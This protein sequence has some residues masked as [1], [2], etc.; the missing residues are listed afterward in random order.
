MLAMP[1]PGPLQAFATQRRTLLAAGMA[2]LLPAV[3]Q[4]QAPAPQPALPAEVLAELQRARIPVSALAC[5]A[6][7]LGSRRV[8]LE[9]QS[10]QMMNPA[11]VVK[12]VTTA[13]ALDQLGPAW[14]WAT[15]VWIRGTPDARGVLEGNVH[16]QGSGDPK[17]VF[18]RVW[19][20]L[21]RVQQMGVRDLRG[22]FVLD[23]SAFAAPEATPGDFDGEHLR[24]YNAQPAA[25]LLNYSARVYGFVPDPAREVA[26]V[27]IEPPLVG[28]PL[29]RSVPLNSGPCDD[30]RAGLQASFNAGRP[31]FA[32]SYP[33][34]CGERQ[35]VLADP[36][37]ASYNRRLIEGLWR[38]MG[39]RLGGRVRSGP[40]PAGPPSFEIRSPPLLDVVRDIN[41]FSNNVMAQQ[42][43][44]TLAL[45]RDPARPATAEAARENLR[46]WLA[47]RLGPLPAETVIDN[48]SGLSRLTRMSAAT[49]VAL[50]QLAWESPWMSELISS[51]PV[52]GT[53][54]T[55][56]RSRAGNGRAH[57]KT[58]TLRDSAALA[59]VVLGD[60]GRRYAFV[61]MVNHP[62]AA[63]ARQALDALVAWT[64]RD[65]TGR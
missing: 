36:E 3:L 53:D 10:R 58:G 54:G 20:L 30:W 27:T 41:K 64:M 45:Q 40:A 51:L 17:L 52:S 19:L 21:R 6:Q 18:E 44:L 61:A 33:A 11:S 25:L 32:G 13:A 7:E 49:L 35:W 43:A 4:A 38:E 46:G 29:E 14:S 56:R 42:L 8:V 28:Q 22:D 59:G 26:V 5:L 34:A 50:L 9:H 24:A 1:A 12:L 15:P 23:S 48:G 62:G 16:I 31:R 47:E 37:P 55:L 65:G 63:A 2:S 60:S 57:L 39:G